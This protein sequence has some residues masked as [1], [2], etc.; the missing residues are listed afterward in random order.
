[1]Q[2]C[3]TPC[4]IDGVGATAASIFSSAEASAS[5]LRVSSAPEAS[6]RYSLW[7]ETPSATRRAT[8]GASRS[9]TIQSRKKAI[10]KRPERPSRRPAVRPP[11]QRRPRRDAVRDEEDRARERRDDG[12]E[13]NV[14]IAHMRHLVRDHSLEL[15]AVQGVDRSA[16][17]GDRRAG[18]SGPRGEGVGVGIGDDPDGGLG[19]PGRDRHLLDDV[20]ERAL[21]RIGGVHRPGGRRFEDRAGPPTRA[22]TR[23]K[24]RRTPE[25]RSCRSADPATRPRRRGSR[26]RRGRGTRGRSRWPRGRARCAP[27][28]A[29]AARRG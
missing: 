15:L 19:E 9:E 14:E 7:R 11:P 28:C 29:A 4:L 1:M 25:R 26:R 16:C 24:G 17:H 2:R 3:A 21:C 20:V 22:P 27:G 6:A 23:R 10:P 13:A 8:I 12:H 5:G 18:R